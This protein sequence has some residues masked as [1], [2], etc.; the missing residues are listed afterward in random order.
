MKN[1]VHFRILSYASPFSNIVP[2]FVIFTLLAIIFNITS[3][4]FIMPILQVLFEKTDTQFTQT[5]MPTFEL[6]IAYFSNLFEY[7]KYYLTSGDNPQQ[8][9]QRICLILMVSVIFSNVFNYLSLRILGKIRAR[10]VRS[11]RGEVYNKIISLP[12]GYYS[13]QKKGDVLSRITNDI[14]EV[15]NAVVGMLNV[16][17]K[18][19]LT[20][21]CI[22]V[23][24][25]SLSLKLTIFTIIVLPLSGL[26]I[27]QI[28]KRLRKVSV[29][30]QSSLGSILGIIDE[31]IVGLRI[32]KAFNAET[33]IKDK[34]QKINQCYYK[35]VR[36]M[37]NR[38]RLAS[39]VSQVLGVSVVAATIYYGGGLVL[40]HDPSLSITPQAFFGYIILL[41]TVLAPLK[42]MANSVSMIQRGIA[43][44]S[45]VFELLDTESSIQ[46]KPNAKT[47]KGFENRIEFVGLRFKYE[48]E[49]VLKGLDFCIKKG[50]TIALVGPSGGGKSTM[51]DLIPRFYDPTAGRVMIDGQDLRD[52]EMKSLR[53]L[54]GIVSQESILF[55]D[56]IANNIA[57]GLN[58]SREEIEQAAKAANA[59]EFIVASEHGYDTEIGDRG[60]NLSGGQRQRLTIARAI[61]K[62]PPIMLLDEATSALDSESEKLVQAALNNLMKNRTSIVI[63]HRL[64]T[65]QSA[66]EI[67]V[68]KQGQIVEKGTHQ[69]LLELG[70]LYKKLSEMQSA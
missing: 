52:F 18:D 29:E 10:V 66:D 21:F 39:P 28:T 33:Y 27:G 26:V 8:I 62:N 67:L 55:N 63:A 34:F 46:D 47:I 19:P 22:F 14:Q 68:V 35:I 1:K 43:S 50:K 13:S 20:I 51:M 31:S 54:M 6:S 17:F 3:L 25:F 4:S 61:L 69:T 5:S 36:A 30:G 44:G 70:G 64:S 38:R 58:V 41:A 53:S 65:I 9:L 49:E 24:L 7:I 23:V 2:G 48:S 32:V 11:L 60:M 12:I 40:S 59:H 42:S 45:R 56:T 16:W 37:E 15:E 57:F